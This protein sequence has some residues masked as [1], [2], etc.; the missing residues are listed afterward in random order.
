MTSDEKQGLRSG[1]PEFLTGDQGFLTGEQWFVTGKQGFRQKNVD[2]W[3]DIS[4]FLTRDKD[5]WRAVISLR[6]VILKGRVVIS[7]TTV[8][9]NRRRVIAVGEH[10]FL[11]GYECPL[12][13]S[14]VIS[15]RRS[16]QEWRFL[17]KRTKSSSTEETGKKWGESNS[18]RLVLRVEGSYQEDEQGGSGEVQWGKVLVWQKGAVGRA[19]RTLTPQTWA[20]MTNECTDVHRQ[21]RSTGG[22][23]GVSAIPELSCNTALLSIQEILIKAFAL[24]INYVFLARGGR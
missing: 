20:E 17:F 16:W 6:T 22:K 8:I 11:T 1:E 24:L 12:H 19:S 4:G 9:S 5:F 14:G 2:F 15:N 21:G 3:Q 23:S 7:D 18:L 13:R 10:G